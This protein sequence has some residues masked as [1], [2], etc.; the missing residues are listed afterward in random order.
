MTHLGVPAGYLVL[1]E[2][3][4][5]TA[6]PDLRQSIAF[7]RTLPGDGSLFP[8]SGTFGFTAPPNQA[9]ILT[10]VDWQFEFGVANSNVTLRVFLTWFEPSPGLELTRRVL[11]STILLGSQG[12]GGTS[13]VAT[14]GVLVPHGVKITVDV[15]GSGA[16][17]RLQ[18]VLMRGYITDFD[19]RTLHG[20]LID[21]ASVLAPE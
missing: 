16:T 21:E 1:L 17:G 8:T 10:E 12:G 7:F 15:A 18:H 6:S 19:Q 14:T 3:I 9:L 20:S 11:E 2:A 13:T 5:V 4:D